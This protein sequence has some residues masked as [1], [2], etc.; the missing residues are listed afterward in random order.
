MKQLCSVWLILLANIML[1]VHAFV[2]H[3]HHN[4]Q[5]CFDGYSVNITIPNDGNDARNNPAHPT[6]PKFSLKS[7]VRISSFCHNG[8]N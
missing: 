2:P 5:V 1:Q 3:H 6:D 8:P 7:T 4:G